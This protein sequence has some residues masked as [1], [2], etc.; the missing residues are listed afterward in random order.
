MKR[1]IVMNLLT[2]EKRIA[3]LENDKTVEFYFTH[4][5]L[6][7]LS[8]N[9]Y[10]GRIT[11]VLP[12]MQ[13]VF[14]DIGLERN[15]FLHRDQLLSYQL[16][17][18]PFEEKRKKSIS[19]FARE[20][21]L[22][23]VQVEK[24]SVGN[25]GPKL[26][27]IIELTGR[28]FVYV[29]KGN[30]IAVSK[31]MKNEAVRTLWRN[32][33][34]SLLENHEGAI[35]R[36]AAEKTEISNIKKEL[37]KLRSDYNK[38]DKQ[39]KALNKPGLLI[40]T[41]S[42]SDKIIQEVGFNTI[43]H[44]IVDEFTIYQQLL[45][46]YG[47]QHVTYYRD[48][49]NIF[50]RYHIEEEIERLHKKNVWLSNGAY[51]VIEHTEAMTIIDVNT[52]KFTGKTNLKDTVLR[53][54]EQAAVEI[55]RQIRLRDIGGIILVDFI[56]MKTETDKNRVLRIMKQELGRDRT[57]TIVY[58]FTHLGVL[59]MTRKRVRENVL[60]QQTQTC[61]VCGNGHVQAKEALAYK[62]ERELFELKGRDEEGVWIEATGD[63]IDQFTRN[64]SALIDHLKKRL[65]ME[66]VFS[67]RD[68]PKPSYEIRHI[69]SILDIH[70]RVKG[71]D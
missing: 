10:A 33:M 26:T 7:D 60:H 44:I 45:E 54:N 9:I 20:G 14:V 25:K 49:E 66:L 11:R 31:K 57:R 16:N 28:Y 67:E 53:T 2:S 18:L 51:L 8:G 21:E 65:Q 47:Q 64:Q 42:Q 56:D 55:A 23:I 12:G 13:A 15:G 17:A 48:R 27:N 52:G 4:P 46:K 50:A 70:N 19:E 40:N 37:D 43:D 29:P 61:Q 30:Y 41:T 3:V 39:L 62:L 59:E 63:I 22:I 34:Q 24:N 35:V 36:T 6:E 5:Q 1:T 38:L 58:G 71:I 68:A 69:G 32:E